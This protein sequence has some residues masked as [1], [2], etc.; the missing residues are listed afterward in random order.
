VSAKL[1][2]YPSQTTSRYFLLAD[3]ESR[4]AGRETAN[5]VVL[6]DPRVSARHAR[7]EWSGP[8]WHL[9]DL[10]SKN[11]T[12][13]NGFPVC[14]PPL[15]DEDWISFG[16]LLCQFEMLSESEVEALRAE[17]GE[18]LRTTAGLRQELAALREPRA[19][20][21]RLLD[22]VLEVTGAER[23]F[24]LLLGRDG[25]L[26]AEIAAGFSP[27]R[28]RE[29]RF[30]GSLG[31]IEAALRGGRTVVASDAASD[32][33]LRN[34]PSV[35]ELGIAALACVPLRVDERVIGLIYVDGH[36]RGGGFTDLDVEILEALADQAALVVATAKVERQ[37]RELLGGTSAE[38]GRIFDALEQQVGE[39]A[40]RLQGERLAVGHIS[41]PA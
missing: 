14:N 4:H 23:G 38:G 9:V 16:G 19:L 37:I 7:F 22:S 36:K 25:A 18:R 21:S 28:L 15:S 39:I 35:V 24:V 5:D 10:G 33:A 11:G 1:T 29:G 3:G 30:A 17:R 6:E 34:R 8:G 2:L 27:E 26:H 40:R 20:L 31:A 32:A 13:V 12:F 41:P